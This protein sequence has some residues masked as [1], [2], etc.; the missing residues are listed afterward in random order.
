MVSRLFS[1]RSAMCGVVLRERMITRVAQRVR[2]RSVRETA[3]LRSRDKQVELDETHPET[4]APLP[5]CNLADQQLDNA[6]EPFSNFQ[7][8]ESNPGTVLAACLSVCLSAERA[9]EY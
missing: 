9:H 4:T 8:L 2:A 5:Q 3:R 1:C 7:R 6:L